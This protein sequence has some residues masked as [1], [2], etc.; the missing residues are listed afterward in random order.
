MFKMVNPLILGLLFYSSALHSQPSLRYIEKLTNNQGLTS[1][2]ITDILQDNRGFLWIATK[3]GLNRYDGTEVK[4]FSFKP[5][6]QSISHNIIY[7]L[8]KLDDSRI[9]L[10]TG[11]GISILNIKNEKFQNIIFPSDSVW[12]AYDNKILFLEKDASG[13]FWAGTSTCIYWLDPAF[14]VKKKITALYR[15]ED[16]QKS[17]IG[18]VFKI[19]PLS[20]GDVLFWLTTGFF[21]WK[22]GRN[23]FVNLQNTHKYSFLRGVSFFNCYQVYGHYLFYVKPSQDSFLIY[24]EFSGRTAS[25]KT[26]NSVSNFIEPL[27]SCETLS[28]GWIASSF[29]TKGT[30]FL[31]MQDKDGKISLSFSP[32]KYLNEYTTRVWMQDKEKNWWITTKEEGLLK[33]TPQKQIFK[34]KD[35]SVAISKQLSS[36]EVNSFNRVGDDLF[37]STDGDGLYEWN[38][39]SAKL[40]R[41]LFEKKSSLMNMVWNSRLENKDT[42]WV[43]T[44]EGLFWYN[45]KNKKFGRLFQTYPKILDS[46]AITT[47]FTDSKGFVWMGLGGGRG[48][49]VYNPVVKQFQIIPNE[50]GGYPFRYPLAIAEDASHDLWFLSDNV[51][52]LVRW[53]RKENKFY[54]IILPQFKG[55][56]YNHTGNFY[57][58]AASGDIWFGVQSTGLVCYN[59]NNGKVK[60]YGVE[61]G[62][63]T[64][65]IYNINQDKQGRLWLA[66]AQGLTSFDLKQERFI[67]YTTSE[68]LP[69]SF[70]SSQ[71]YYDT[72]ND[73][74]YAG[75]PG[76]ITYFATNLLQNEELPLRVE[77]TQ[78][79]I[80]D[81]SVDLPEERKLKL[82]WNRSDIAVSF[83][84]INLTNGSENIY[85]YK[86][87]DGQWIDLGNQ[88]QIR[89]ASLKP[90][91]YDITIRA[92]RKNGNWSSSTDHLQLIITPP[93]TSTVWFYLIILF[94]FS[95]LIYGWYRYRLLQI[96]KLEKMR[97]RISH[98]LHDEIG[99][100]L[101]NIG[102]MSQIARQ[103]SQFDFQKEELLQ[104]I[105]E[106]SEAVSQNMREI[107]WNV[108]PQNDALEESMPRM[109]RYASD[110]LDAKM[111]Y[112]EA[113]IPDLTGIKMDMEKRRDL[114]LIFKE[115]IHNMVKHSDAGKATINIKI[116][117]KKM[118]LH[119]WDD[120]KGFNEKTLPY[121]NGLQNMKQRA[122]KHRW[123]LTVQ[124]KK[125]KG[126]EVSL[127]IGLDI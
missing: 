101:T 69:S 40:S 110:M 4:N 102:L 10:A 66:T 52:H 44:A 18:F 98:D 75:S 61:K 16:I 9:V 28:D 51:P 7:R 32:T 5:Q 23:S 34:S 112:V 90:G 82:P 19:L 78:M 81:N 29:E 65:M 91:K 55:S 92:S 67:N 60:I 54:T 88:H 126:T 84:G 35:L 58:N 100:R 49:A 46:P 73:I 108:N 42:L 24:D 31:R 104:R 37:I 43:G 107:I 89:F 115:A 109:L 15:P 70:Y 74:M 77:F 33:L 111:I 114:F 122:Y 87:N 8:I 25:C 21:V 38:L 56:A 53:S 127:Q 27:A 36:Y 13:N 85:Q 6:G 59:I 62:L 11:H 48:V 96:M 63:S 124:S 17:R 103:K 94:G 26:F 64:D 116:T 105:Q 22:P 30:I 71:L 118:T 76:R 39:S 119:L 57:L 121:Q 125:N 45:I 41:H 79:Q 93:F 72:Q 80:G 3:Y 2:A 97:S 95:F 86:L 83:T 106:E 1:N 120:G 20:S 50:P 123:E 99:S 113:S 68:G 12:E 14:R 47:Q 117:D